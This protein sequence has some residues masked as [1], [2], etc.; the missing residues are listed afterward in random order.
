MRGFSHRV[1]VESALAWLDEQLAPL[2]SEA[3]DVVTAAGRVLAG[4][5]SSKVDVP[6]FRRAMMDGYAVQAND[7]LGASSYNRLRLSIVGQQLPG[8]QFAGQVNAE[9]AVR[10]MTGAALPAGADA[11][12]PVEKTESDGDQ[13]FALGEV[14]PGKHVGDI[15]EDV[16]CGEQL[17]PVGRRLRPQD[18]GVLISAG[19]RSIEVVRQPRVRIVVTGNELLAPG[20]TPRDAMIVDSNSPMLTGLITRDG[21]VTTRHD[22]IADE[23]SAITEALHDDV[24]VVLVSGGSSVGQEDHAPML[25]ARD[26]ELAIHGVAMR[27][28]S[29]A[30]MGR[31]GQRLV[32]LLPGNPVSC[33]CAYDFFAGRAIRQLSG[34][35]AGWPY[36]IQRLRLSRKLVSAV[37]RVDYARVRIVNDE[38][39]PL[40]ISGASMLSST[41]RA[42]GF[43]IVPGDS[44]GLGAG[45]EVD[46]H[47][48]D[49]EPTASCH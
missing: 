3:S 36:P 14:S 39:E 47:L 17:L 45:A 23:P 7:T 19:V 44:E 37:G 13:L 5:V 35:S 49:L 11:V 20:S 2:K 15:G 18:V 43:V 21:G 32:F 12:L 9:Q 41:T 27:P 22:I 25:L 16:K 1:T 24:D 33:L 48:Y 8:Q 46:V 31:L 6:A 38:V 40:A 26:G 42:D 30:G 28:S 10:I 29:P 4:P 34:R